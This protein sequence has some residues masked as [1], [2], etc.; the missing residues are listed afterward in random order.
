MTQV[1]TKGTTSYIYKYTGMG[2]NIILK[3]IKYVIKKGVGTVI[4]TPVI[5]GVS[6]GEQSIKQR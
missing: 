2:N 6:D 1:K 4:R 3:N 5:T